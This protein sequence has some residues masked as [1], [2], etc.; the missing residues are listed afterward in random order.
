VSAPATEHGL[1]V[2]AVR[3]LLAAGWKREDHCELRHPVGSLPYVNYQVSGNGSIGV[4]G[5]MRA[6]VE[7]VEQAVDLLVTLQLLPASM[8]SLSAAVLAQ[9]PRYVPCH[10]CGARVPADTPPPVD[11]PRHDGCQP[12]VVGGAR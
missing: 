11:G 1:F 2:Q 6:Y 4:A 3:H 12:I 7:T 5:R 10:V 8:H 9:P